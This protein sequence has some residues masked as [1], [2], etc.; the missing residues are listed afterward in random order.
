[1]EGGSAQPPNRNT[2]EPPSPQAG[3]GCRAVWTY[4]G[5][6]AGPVRRGMPGK[7]YSVVSKGKRLFVR[8]SNPRS[9]MSREFVIPVH[10]EDLEVP[11]E[12]RMHVADTRCMD[13]MTPAQYR[14]AVDSASPRPARRARPAG[15]PRLTPRPAAL[16]D[17]VLRSDGVGVAEQ[18]LFDR[19]FGA[20]KSVPTAAAPGRAPPR[21]DPP[22]A[23]GTCGP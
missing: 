14:K 10:A 5:E 20:V 2:H 11:R 18:G 19:V 23:A 7:R 15:P 8:G 6:P 1:M 17:D 9:G 16:Q 13:G 22:A 4:L 21:S 3:I 12:D